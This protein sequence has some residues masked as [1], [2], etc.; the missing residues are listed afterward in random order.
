MSRIDRIEESLTKI[1]FVIW[2]VLFVFGIVFLASFQSHDCKY[3]E[4]CEYDVNS[5]TK[6]NATSMQVSEGVYRCCWTDRS[7]ETN[8][9]ELFL[10]IILFGGSMAVLKWE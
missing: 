1:R 4:K 8:W 6:T 5:C 3:S 10:A 7:C 9:V 2:I